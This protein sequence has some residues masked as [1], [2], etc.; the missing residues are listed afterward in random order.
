MLRWAA[1]PVVLRG[2]LCLRLPGILPEC[3]QCLGAQAYAAAVAVEH[4]MLHELGEKYL[5]S[6]LPGDMHLLR[7]DLPCNSS[8]H[9]L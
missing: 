1:R 7:C 2:A 5:A 8:H 3:R 6:D 9:G 4:P